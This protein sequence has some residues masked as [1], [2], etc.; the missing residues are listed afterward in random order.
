VQLTAK[1]DGCRFQSLLECFYSGL[2]L[3]GVSR[4]K[5]NRRRTRPSA[6]YDPARRALIRIKPLTQHQRA[7]STWG[8]FSLSRQAKS[9]RCS[10]IRL[11][12]R[13]RR[14]WTAEWW[15]FEMAANKEIM[16]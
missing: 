6:L 2:N 16:P 7:H 12:I 4:V 14:G 3:V 1:E 5:G 8:S 15:C 9:S 13:R 10:T 11:R